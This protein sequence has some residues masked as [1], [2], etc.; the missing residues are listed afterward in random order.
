MKTKR[1]TAPTT[2]K[3]AHDG[4]K[5]TFNTETW[6]VTYGGITFQSS[7]CQLGLKKAIDRAVAKQF[8]QK[9]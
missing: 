3:F 4:K 5:G 1:V 9:M 8:K 6:Q 2:I 7:A